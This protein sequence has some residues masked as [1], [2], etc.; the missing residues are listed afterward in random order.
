LIDDGYVSEEQEAEEDQEGGTSDSEEGSDV[1]EGLPSP[2]A[3]DARKPASGSTEPEGVS[4]EADA[5]GGEAAASRE[6]SPDVEDDQ[7]QRAEGGDEQQACADAGKA[8]PAAQRQ[9]K[10]QRL[11]LDMEA[12]LR[13][14][15]AG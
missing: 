9:G 1:A 10:L 2:E 5:Q 14:G 13:W 6:A 15:L 11:F 7:H 4:Q 8:L 3:S 12:E